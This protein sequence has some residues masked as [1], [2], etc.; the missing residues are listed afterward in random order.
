M[1][2]VNILL[3]CLKDKNFIND[4]DKARSMV[5]TETIKLRKEDDFFIR[6]A[7]TGMGTILKENLEHHY[8]I[9]TVRMGTFG[10]TFTQA[11]IQRIGSSAVIAVYGKEGLIKKHLADK[12]IQ[13]LKDALY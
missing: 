9:T 2:T 6:D 10:D 1:D 5:L 13:K 4:I 8:Y 7:I 3:K 12:T 11:I